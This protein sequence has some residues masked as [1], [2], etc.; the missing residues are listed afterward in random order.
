L[1]SIDQA[2]LASLDLVFAQNREGRFIYINSITARAFGSRRDRLMG[3]TFTDLDLP[4][5]VIQQLEA[6]HQ[7]IFASGQPLTGEIRFPAFYQDQLKDYEYTFSP[8]PGASGHLEAAIF[9]GKDITQRKQAEIALQESEK[10]YRL[11]FESAN[12]A[13]F[14]ADCNT[15]Q[16]LNA[17]WSAARRLGYSRREL[18]Q[19]SI[20]EIECPMEPDLRESILEQLEVE[21]SIIYEHYYRRKDGT[22]IPVEINA[23]LIEYEEHLALQCFVRDISQRKAAE[24]SLREQQQ[25]LASIAANFPGA[26]YRV[27]VSPDGQI[28]L[29]YVSEG[30]RETD[31]YSAAQLMAEPQ[32][33][34]QSIHPDDRP[35]VLKQIED[36]RR[37]LQPLDLEYRT[38]PD[39]HST[40]WVREVARFFQDEEG[41]VIADG[42]VLDVSD[43]KEAQI[44]L[45]RQLEQERLL[46]QVT[47]H[48]HQSLHLDTTLQRIVED[49]RQYL[50]SDR[51]L[52]FR[53]NADWSG[54][55]VV[56][57][58][59]DPTF[60]IQGWQA[61]SPCPDIDNFLSGNALVAS[62]IHHSDLY[63]SYVDV[64]FHQAQVRA[65]LTVPIMIQQEGEAVPSEAPSVKPWGILVVHHCLEVREWQEHEVDLLEKLATQAGI[66]IYQAELYQ[67]LQVE[68][69]ERRRIEAEIRILNADLEERVLRRTEELRQTN[70]ELAAEV[71]ERLRAEVALRQ[72]NQRYET[73]ANLSPVGIFRTNAAGQCIYCNQRFMEILGYAPDDCAQCPKDSQLHPDDRPTALQTWQHA[74]D[75]AIPYHMECR[76]IKPNGDLIWTITQGQP[77]LDAEGQFLGFVNTITDITE[78]KRAEAEIRISRKRLQSLID[79]LPFAVWARDAEER[80]ILQNPVDVQRF[81]NLLGTCPED[82]S[83][84]PAIVQRYRQARKAVQNS[85]RLEYETV[86]AY[87]G[88]DRHFLRIISVFPDFD[89]RQ[90]LLG[91]VIDITE[92]KRAE[93]ALQQ[94]EAQFRSL[95]E[96]AAVGIALADTDH[97]M[98]RVNEKLCQ[99][100]GYSEA[101]L[102]ALTFR[103]F[104]HPDD[105]DQCEIS[106]DRMIQESLPNQSLE[107]RC[108]RKD[109][110]TIWI[111]TTISTVWSET[112]QVE[113]YCIIVDDISDRKQAELALQASEIRFRTVFDNAG[114]GIVVSEP[115]HYDFRFS[116]GAFCA[117]VGYS[118][119]ELVSLTFS[120]LTHPE[121]LAQEMVLVEACLV[122][123][124]DRYQVE[125]RYIHK[126][127]SIVWANLMS[128]VVRDADGQILFAIG[129]VEDITTRKLNE[130]AQHQAELALQASEARQRAI[131]EAIPDLLFWVQ[132]DGRYLETTRRKRMRDLIAEGINPEG[133][134][135]WDFLPPSVAQRK[136]A[137]IEQAL[138]TNS[139]QIY[140]QEFTLGD[141]RQYEEVRVIPCEGGDTVLVM[142][143]DISKRRQAELAQH[144]AE[145]ALRESEAQQRAILEAFP[146]TL[147]WVRADGTMIKRIR[148]NEAFT[149]IPSHIQLEG[150]HL[151]ELLPPDVAQAQLAALQ[152]A[153]AKG[154]LEIFEDTI[155][156]SDRT[157]YREIR[158]VPTHDDA[159]LV[160]VRDVSDRKRAEIQLQEMKERYE[161]AV[162]GIGEVIWDWD[163]VQDRTYVSPQH[164]AITGY[165]PKSP[166]VYTYQDYVDLVHPEDWE[167]VE[168]AIHQHFQQKEPFNVEYRIRHQ[169]GQYIWIRDRAQAIWDSDDRPI[170]MT[171]TWA[172]ITEFKRLGEALRQSEASYRAIVELQAELVCR[173]RPDGSLTFANEAYCQYFQ[174]P[175]DQLNQ[176]NWLSF[177]PEEQR[178]PIQ[179]YL[180]TLD[181]DNPVGGY[182]HMVITPSGETRWHQWS[183]RALFDERGQVIEYQSVGR[184]I[185]ERKRL[186]QALEQ[187]QATLNDV[188][189][190]VNASI[191]QSRFRSLDDITLEFISPGC[192][193]V[194]GFTPEEFKADLSLWRSRVDPADLEQVLIPSWQ[195]LEINQKDQIVYRYHHPDGQTRWIETNAIARYDAIH[196][197]WIVTSIE[198][199]ITQRFVSDPTQ[200]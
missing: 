197:A 165:A 125:K 195:R 116:N 164:W 200:P 25:Q 110:T 15:L 114:F 166:D 183:D 97:R 58:V 14:I 73:L 33:M 22:E 52:I 72:S 61:A 129:L 47:E 146:D 18:M 41:N 64:L 103:D 199:D 160:V 184:D 16:I 74:R 188:L 173:F 82:L 119:D 3:Q 134:Y 191:V 81:G 31:G 4:P 120:D 153:L 127:G 10:K 139:I 136:A 90:G 189:E 132:K 175:M 161:L 56:E 107:K 92:R 91:A 50:Q 30:I 133:R 68:L 2:L 177:I 88:E 43:R 135:I 27:V 49:V 78:L 8:V 20:R 70:L 131:L 178:R 163:I 162:N 53:F 1:S 26:I 85:Q 138:A 179:E 167:R 113:R 198:T 66:G 123:G 98:L 28:C 152:R 158:I 140:E 181:M 101:E 7:A 118:P 121:D 182:E 193:L 174:I 24:N 17:N 185:T 115:P 54:H 46:R 143:R 6:N 137:A 12:D 128:T 21:G 176:I 190:H 102:Y 80:L 196:Q 63:Q 141:Q 111:R 95:F 149:L 36:S 96:N 194:F 65:M 35:T 89:G 155:L 172:D 151:S 83:C 159:A 5:A 154:S 45:Q 76:Y 105:L 44:A 69:Q 186:E 42:V 112:G 38:C 11:L 109:G 150:K 104:T 75:Q 59:S 9:I 67:Q 145:A 156:R 93:L 34:L 170:R 126:N 19:L 169:S 124:C 86:E 48:I 117:L 87:Q 62:D 94:S 57:S 29:P 23:Q 106:I 84:N 180:T 40:K 99:I 192:E 144:Q 171:G 108:V 168:Q 187:A 148:T 51:V 37:I 79:A 130:A 77:E 55:I 142:V 100:L 32:L 147:S 157:H 122:G 60:S 13:I 39:E 71:A